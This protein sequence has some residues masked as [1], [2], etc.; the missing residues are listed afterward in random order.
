MSTFHP[1]FTS[2]CLQF[3]FCVQR[4]RFN[5]PVPHC[6]LPTFLHSLSFYFFFLLFPLFPLAESLSPIDSNL[7][8]ISKAINIMLT[9]NSLYKHHIWSGHNTKLS[10]DSWLCL[11]T[12]T[13]LRI[14]GKTEPGIDTIDLN[15]SVLTKELLK[16]II[17]Q[18]DKTASLED[19]ISYLQDKKKKKILFLAANIFKLKRLI[20]EIKVF[21]GGAGMGVVRKTQSPDQ[22]TISLRE[23]QPCIWI[24]LVFSKI[25]FFA[26]FFFFS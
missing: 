26:L 15:K 16:V 23:Q 10:F 1:F 17:R 24:G 25:H 13:A 12:T 18:W 9:L 4:P 7:S 20:K 3:L 21:H 11:S 6:S 14:L 2:L 22:G 5:H 19:H 8:H